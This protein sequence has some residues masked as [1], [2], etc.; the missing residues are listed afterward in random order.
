MPY[1]PSLYN[2]YGYQGLA[3]SNPQPIEGI[4]WVANGDE[5][6]NYIMPPNSQSPPLMWRDEPKFS[7]KT[8]DN[9][10]GFSV[11]HFSFTED[12]P[13]KPES[14]WATKDDLES[15]RNEILEAING[16]SAVSE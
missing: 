2:P 4:T 8:T 13:E 15:M 7:I 12:E 14:P 6:A 9:Y 1:N 16:K 3:P 5:A 10:G 11:R